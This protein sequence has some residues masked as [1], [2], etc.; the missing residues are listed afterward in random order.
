MSVLSA[1]SVHGLPIVSPG[2]LEVTDTVLPTPGLDFVPFASSSV[3]VTVAVVDWPTLTV[4]LLKMTAVDVCLLFTV[5]VLEPVLPLKV[6]SPLKVPATPP[7]YVPTAI[8][9]RLTP[10]SVATPEALVVAVP[11]LVS[12]SLKL[13]VLLPTPVAPEVSVAVRLTVPPTVPVAALT[14][15]VVAVRFV[16]APALL[17]PCFVFAW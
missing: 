4:P 16:I 17:V 13:I 9:E 1:A 12:S 6:A 5:S 2:T 14:V 8:P 11:T 15:S 7:G 3:T 10:L